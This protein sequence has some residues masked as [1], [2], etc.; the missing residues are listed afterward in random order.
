MERHPAH[1]AMLFF[2]P[3]G[4]F[5]I[6]ASGA[7]PKLESGLRF[8]VFGEFLC[9]AVTG[10]RHRNPMAN[11]QEDFGVFVSGSETTDKC[12]RMLWPALRDL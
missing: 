9:R 8:Q 11:F 5:E 12:S 10:E 6:A 2:S 3:H 4:N 7:R 1:T